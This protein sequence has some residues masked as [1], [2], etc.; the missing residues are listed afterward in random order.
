M[1]VHKSFELLEHEMFA[2]HLALATLLELAAR[3]HLAIDSLADK[4]VATGKLEAPEDA[5]RRQHLWEDIR[6]PMKVPPKRKATITSP[7]PELASVAKS[8]RK[9]KTRKVGRK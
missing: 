7:S 2:R 1:F 4:A 5:S 9:N 8:A 6:V 3:R